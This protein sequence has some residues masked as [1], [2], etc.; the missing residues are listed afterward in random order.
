MGEETKA[1]SSVTGGCLC[2]AVRY[3]ATGAPFWVGHCHC[4]SCRRHTGAPLVTFVGFKKDQVAFTEGERQIYESSP[5]VGRA[6][7]GRCGTPLTWEGESHLSGRG[8]IVEF[9]ISTLD[10]PGAFRPSNHVFYPERIAWFDVADDL[11][12]HEGFDFDTPLCR[13]GPTSDNLPG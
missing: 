3:R 5:G 10:D 2:G 13:R 9:H 4:L 12:R 7:C 1:G 11:P 6:F 8:P